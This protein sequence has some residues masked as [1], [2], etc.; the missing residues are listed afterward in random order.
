LSTFR[1]YR[2]F[3]LIPVGYPQFIQNGKNPVSHRFL[4][5]RILI[6]KR[7]ILPFIQHNLLIIKDILRRL[8]EKGLWF[9]QLQGIRRVYLPLTVK[10]KWQDSFKGGGWDTI[11]K[12]D[13]PLTA[14]L[15]LAGTLNALIT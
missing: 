12:T 9:L 6:L 3:C 7:F 4:E 5:N 1:Y 8:K 11:L 10:I 13:Q 14:V 15:A 2:T